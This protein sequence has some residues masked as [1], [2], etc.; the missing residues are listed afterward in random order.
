MSAKARRRR[1]RKGAAL[2]RKA[3]IAASRHARSIDRAKLED[4]VSKRNARL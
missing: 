2:M 3:G 1:A 4:I